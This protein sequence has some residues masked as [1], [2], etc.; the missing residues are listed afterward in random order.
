MTIREFYYDYRS[1]VVFGVVL[2]ILVVMSYIFSSLIPFN[3]Y[4]N[5][6]MPILYTMIITFCGSSMYFFWRHHEGKRMRKLIA[7]IMG[8]WA[9][10]S[11]IGLGIKLGTGLPPV[12]EGRFS[13]YG[14]EFVIG[15]ILAWMLLAYPTEVLRPGWLNVKKGALQ[16]VPILLIG[17]LGWWLDIDVR[18]LLAVYPVLLIS[19]LAGHMR[20]YKKWCEEN[21]ASMEDIDVQWI[22]RYLVM[23]AITGGSFVYLCFSNEPTY[24]FTQLWLLF[25][26]LFYSTEK[27]LFRP[28][29]WENMQY[30][31]AQEAVI[32]AT[33]AQVGRLSD[34]DMT[35]YRDKLEQWMQTDKPYK[36]KDFRL[37]DLMQVLPMNRTYL[38]Q[39]LSSM[40]GRNFYQ[41]VDNYR[42][43]EAKRLMRE[44]PGMKL[45]DISDECGFS[46]PTVFGRT[47]ARETGCSPS[48]WLSKLDNK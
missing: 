44:K 3:I 28:D 2:T 32:E 48:E 9:G 20:K 25:F 1:E 24:S 47:F 39:F 17:L 15:D 27:I 4:W 22:V 43:E 5:I 42:L 8:L 35:L 37:N 26:V 34:E 12:A 21:Y 13:L 23:V 45:Q 7:I 46:S 11:L 10:M 31:E 19:I 38:S 14:W 40:F 41:Y 6:L 36:N 18:W 30:A 33:Q 29:P 16:I